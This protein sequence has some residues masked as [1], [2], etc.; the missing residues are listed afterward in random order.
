MIDDILWLTQVKGRDLDDYLALGWYRMGKYIFTTQLLEAPDKSKFNRV[1]W[2]RYIV[3]KVNFDTKT[4][5]L[6]NKNKRFTVSC[7]PFILTPEV[8]ALHALYVSSLKFQ[9]A[10]DLPYLLVDIKN[11]IFDSY[12]IHV[13]DGGKLISAGIFD[14]GLETIAGIINFYDPAY[15]AFSPGKYLMM[16]KYSFCKKYN[17]K[18]YYP[19]YYS[20]DYPVFDYKLF[21]DKAATEVYIPLF[22][23]WVTFSVF[24]DEFC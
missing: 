3:D 6:W 24:L 2:L 12:I 13:R 5:Q 11:E 18:Y 7:T 21:L 14:K 19:G 20:P 4:L 17:I 15:K 16:L 9:T 10:E 8:E 1:F 23:D 22:G